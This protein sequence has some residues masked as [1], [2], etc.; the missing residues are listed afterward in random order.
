M[1]FITLF[2]NLVYHR[3][4]CYVIEGK[5]ITEQCIYAHQFSCSVVSNS[6]QCHGLD[7]ARLPCPS[8]TPR[9]CSCPSTHV[10]WVSDVIQLSHPL[11]SPS[12]PALNLSQLKSLS[13]WVSSS[14]QVA[15]VLELQLHHRSFQWTFRVDFLQ[16]WAFPFRWKWMGISKRYTVWGHTMLTDIPGRFTKPETNPCH[17]LFT[18][19][20]SPWWNVSWE[21]FFFSSWVTSLRHI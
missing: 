13:Q 7:H 6:L 14:H 4:S 12:P 18:C 3:Y 5:N 21:R 16:D 20:V 11:S 17:F 19:E 15:K 8:P 2:L 9:T 10:H 1:L